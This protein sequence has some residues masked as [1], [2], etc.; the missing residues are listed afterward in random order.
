MR[1]DTGRK[2]IQAGNRR[3]DPGVGI[4]MLT[5][6]IMVNCPTG[7]DFGSNRAQLYPGWSFSAYQV[8]W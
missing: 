7:F 2:I 4:F 6:V 5:W 8:I 1:S 3:I